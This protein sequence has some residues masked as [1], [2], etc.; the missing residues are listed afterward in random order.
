MNV[1]ISHS[2]QNG[3]AALKLCD[4][5]AQRGIQV[6]LDIRELDS[7]ENWNT[8][9]ASA[10]ESADAFVVLI[11]PTQGPDRSQQFE[12]QQ[13]TEREYYLDPDKPM[14]P[15]LMGS[16]D[17]PG[18]LRTRQA[19]VCPPSAIDFDALADR[20]VQALGSPG[21]TIDQDQLQRGRAARDQALQS[22]REYTRSLESEE[23]KLAGLRG[24]K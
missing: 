24:L 2:R 17:M 21:S 7:G 8:A 18:F 6:W 5:L 4:R 13:I 23:V 14:I 3:G 11:G 19:L 15:V 1:F 16:A 10:I 22:L 20:I 9:V 12:W